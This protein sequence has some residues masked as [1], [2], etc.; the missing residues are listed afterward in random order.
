[1]ADFD[2]GLEICRVKERAEGVQ[3]EY[4]FYCRKKGIPLNDMPKQLKDNYIELE[5]IKA[6]DAHKCKTINDINCLINRIAEL[7]N[8]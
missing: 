8:L 2:L 6:H 5:N 1:M 4:L 3:A 7:K